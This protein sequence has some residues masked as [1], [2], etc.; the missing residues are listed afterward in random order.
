MHELKLSLKKESAIPDHFKKILFRKHDLA[1]QLAFKS[2]RDLKL[3]DFSL[4]LTKILKIP[5]FLD[6]FSNPLTF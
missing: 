6:Q 5:S 2:H 1:S 4:F 3:P